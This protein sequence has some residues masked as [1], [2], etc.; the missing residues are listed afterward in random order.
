MSAPEDF[1][2]VLGVQKTAS[3]EEI[4][5]AYRKQ[6]LK[7]H[8]DKNPGDPSA[9]EH[10]KR[11][12]QAYSVLGDPEKRARYDRF[13]TAGEAGGGIPWDSVVFEDFGDLLG[14][15][16]GFGDLFGGGRKRGRRAR[17]G[18]DLRYDVRLTLREA[19]DGKEET[20]D[21]PKEEPCGGCRGT[22]SASGHRESCPACR[23]RGS[24]ALQQGFFTVTRTC[25]QCSGEGDLVRDPCKGCGGRGR[26]RTQKTLKVRIPGGVDNGSRLRVGG[27]GEAGERGGPPGDLYLFLEVAPHDFFR[28]EGDHLICAV[29]LSFPQAVLG[30]EVLVK[31]LEEGEERVKVPP[32]TAHGQRF[33]IPGKGMPRLGSGGRGDLFVDVMLSPPKRPSKEER[34]LYEELA[35]L[36]RESE[37]GAGAFFRKVV[38]RFSEGR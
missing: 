20:L 21:L 14:D 25:P 11:A 37:E 17:R 4:K 27:E 26:L 23:G 32:G 28:R 16:F 10:F 8:P 33:R 18:A 5:A 34:R 30:T 35:R 15:L 31:T 3:P 38:K 12:S 13:G 19:L 36:E 7:Y 24:V 22:G 9:E 1:Y 6:A 2:E 29:P